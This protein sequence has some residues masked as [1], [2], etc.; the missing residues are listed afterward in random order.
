[1][2]QES[3]AP[4]KL[5]EATRIDQTLAVD[6]LFRP[7]SIKPFLKLWQIQISR[8]VAIGLKSANLSILATPH[9]IRSTPF[10]PSLSLGKQLTKIA[11]IA[12]LDS[13]KASCSSS[14]RNTIEMDHE[15]R[16]LVSQF[17]SQ[18][19][20]EYAFTPPGSWYTNPAMLSYE[21]ER[22]FWRGW[23]V[24]GCTK[25]VQNPHDY[26]TGSLGSVQYVICR[27]EQ[28]ELNAFHNVC[29]HHAA[30][31]ASESGCKT[32]F[33]CP[34]HGWT[35]SLD[36]KFQK[37]TRLSGI[38]NFR[39]HDNG[40]LPINVSTWGPFV[41]IN[42]E[43]HRGHSQLD[44]NIIEFEWLG[45]A[46]TRFASAS[47]DADL[48]HVARKEYNINCNW[49]VFCDNYLDG[50][51]HVPFAHRDLAEG[52]SLE[53]YTTEVF[54]KVSVQSCNTGDGS[55]RLGNA[56]FYAF[57][58]PNF[59]INRYGPW[60]DTNLVL[61]ITATRCRVIFDYFLDPSLTGEEKFIKQSL[62]DSETVQMEDIALCEGVQR[63]L[64]SPAFNKGRY[65]PGVEMG[66]YQFHCLLEKD[67]L[68]PPS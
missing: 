49:K 32:C 21:M 39:A 12:A 55:Q 20:I 36:G 18:L 43:A 41:L 23:Q 65:A 3:K 63:G 56:A 30:P 27:N 67:L 25:Q 52:L 5:G 40:L 4:D 38:Q 28:G 64:D 37:A 66:M 26:F 6:R 57:V 42:L 45:N 1:M 68:S 8:T 24:V 53:S 59:M 17:D 61:P 54:E 34:Y 46:S 31:V 60:M 50:G 48:C 51:Y 47:I 19:P 13:S 9:A 22:V 35:Y 14:S 33:I 2:L 44:T 16:R 10:V 29:R 15:I 62:C 58:Y 7:L 11:T